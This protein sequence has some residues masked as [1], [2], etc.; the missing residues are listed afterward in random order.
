MLN[1]RAGTPSPTGERQAHSP[2]AQT[3]AIAGGT[4]NGPL[5]EAQGNLLA[6][7]EL[8]EEEDE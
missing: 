8:L 5:N 1:Y 3:S 6:L 7:L 2:T 4:G